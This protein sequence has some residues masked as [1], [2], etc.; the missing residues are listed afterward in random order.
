MAEPGGQRGP[1]DGDC[2]LFAEERLSALR[3]AVVELSWLL[4][5][6]YSE[7]SARKLVGDRHQLVERQR[8]AVRR[9]SCTEAQL[10]SRA[11]REVA[12]TQVPRLGIDGFNL[13][14]TLE[15]AL[16]GGLV[17]VGRDGALRDL[18][19]VHGNYRS[20][21]HTERTIDLVGQVAAEAEVG[22]LVWYLDRPVSHSGRLRGLIERSLS[23]RPF[24][25]RVELHDAP[26]RVLATDH[27]VVVSSDGYVMDAAPAWTALARAIIEAHVPEAWLVD[28]S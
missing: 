9:A 24:A 27:D 5:R 28:L 19:S 6:G 15:S 26:D 22:E 11:R 1:Q 3:V 21:D 13:I 25:L 12:L 18:A 10:A 23:K 20:L 14:I 4:S 17:L 16:A 8:E 2:E 7:P